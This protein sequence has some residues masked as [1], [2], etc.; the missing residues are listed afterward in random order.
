VTL[1][2]R[3]H[4]SAQK[5][6]QT[7]VGIIGELA[8]RLEGSGRQRCKLVAGMV[9]ISEP[10]C[11]QLYKVSQSFT[12]QTLEEVRVPPTHFVAA[13]YTSAPEAWVKAS[14]NGH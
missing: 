11:R 13:A 14:E 3:L 9:G 10:Y 12:R 8:S 1:F 2:K 4:E 7:R 6:W 5:N